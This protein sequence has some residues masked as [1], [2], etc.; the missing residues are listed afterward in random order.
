M[1][2]NLTHEGIVIEYNSSVLL[3]FDHAHKLGRAIINKCK[4]C[5][6]RDINDGEN[7]IHLHALIYDDKIQL[8]EAITHNYEEHL[9]FA[10]C[11]VSDYQKALKEL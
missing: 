11:S 10:E 3:N 9:N 5:L 4:V 8:F 1:A 2:I 7:K 6:L